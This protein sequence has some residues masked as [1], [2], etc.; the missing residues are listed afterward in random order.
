MKQGATRESQKPTPSRAV[1]FPETA[2]PG[3]SGHWR[4]DAHRGCRTAATRLVGRARH[5]SPHDAPAP[6]A[7]STRPPEPSRN[8]PLPF[9]P[10]ATVRWCFTPDES[11]GLSGRARVVSG[12]GQLPRAHAVTHGTVFTRVLTHEL[13]FS[14]LVAA[15]RQRPGDAHAAGAAPSRGARGLAGGRHRG[16]DA[17]AGRPTLPRPPA[18]RAGVHRPHRRGARNGGATRDSRLGRRGESLR[19]ADVVR[20]GGPHAQCLPGPPRATPQQPSLVPEQDTPRR[21]LGA[22]GRSPGGNVRRGAPCP[23]SGWT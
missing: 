14:M 13:P 20:R 11:G 9:H 15:A 2:Q 22:A 8:T 16:A 21:G 3:H 23:A 7:L 10:A 18:A 1:G 12:S 19:A 6:A 17:R 4:T 5:Q